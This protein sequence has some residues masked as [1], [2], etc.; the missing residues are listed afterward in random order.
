MV[1]G[2]YLYQILYH[3]KPQEYHKS[4]MG[5]HC[6]VHCFHNANMIQSPCCNKDLFSVLPSS[7]I[8]S[9]IHY[10]EK[11]SWCFLKLICRFYYPWIFE[12]SVRLNAK[13]WI[14]KNILII[15]SLLPFLKTSV[16]V[17]ALKQAPSISLPD[18]IY[19]IMFT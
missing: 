3:Q 12:V 15:S 18:L 8:F 2:Q 9:S 17:P 6:A 13:N 1:R 7:N 19:F 14:E 11:V 16:A 10:Y 4:N 5:Y